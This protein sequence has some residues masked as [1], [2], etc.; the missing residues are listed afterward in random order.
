MEEWL[1]D[2]P[3]KSL[4]RLRRVKA[5]RVST[6]NQTGANFDF[7]VVPPDAV[8]SMAEIQGCGCITHIWLTLLCKDPYHLRKIILR[9]FWDGEDNPSVEA[10]LGDFFGIGHA[11]VSSFCSLPF[12]MVVPNRA[13]EHK[14]A[15]IN[16]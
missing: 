12:N 16:C 3:L 11:E 10:P 9:M 8:F 5:R 4:T 7:T 13:N 2:T 6:W 1:H 15:A 14:V